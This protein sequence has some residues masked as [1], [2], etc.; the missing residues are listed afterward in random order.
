M[1]LKVDVVQQIECDFGNGKLKMQCVAAQ[2]MAVATSFNVGNGG[3]GR[4]PIGQGWEEN[5]GSSY[6]SS[7]GSN[8]FSQHR[9]DDK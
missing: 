6:V 4:K 8:K 5:N 1:G 7:Q 2:I 9:L 3:Y